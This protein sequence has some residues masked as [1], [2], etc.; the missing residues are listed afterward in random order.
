MAVTRAVAE[1]WF[2]KTGTPII[3]GYGLSETSP[4]LTCNRA[5]NTEFTG[6][7]GLPVPSTDIAIKDEAGNDLPLG[8]AGEICA[9][10]PQ[11][12]AGY[13]KRPQDTAAV[14]TKDGFFRTGDIGVMDDKG[15]VKIV[16]RKKDMILVS[17]FNVYPNE[18]EDVGREPSRCLGVRGR[19][20]I[21]RKHRR[22]GEAVRG[23]ER[24]RAHRGSAARFRQG[25]AHRL[26]AAEI[27]RIPRG[28]AED[29][30]S[31]RSSAARCATRPRAQRRR[32]ERG[33]LHLPLELQPCE[34]N[35]QRRGRSPRKDSIFPPR[36]GLPAAPARCILPSWP[37]TSAPARSPI[38]KGMPKPSGSAPATTTSATTSRRCCASSRAS[39]RSPFSISA[40]GRGAT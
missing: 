14:M 32:P 33:S 12:M 38:T 7:I 23:E 9:R 19:R 36:I 29:P 8:S 21:G 18:V 2:K 28:T 30:M 31:A 15:Q 34:S 6:T 10:G 20:R 17:G 22:G 39:C 40:A 27:H 11:V 13:W 25:E 26:Q 37:K 16:D 5:D 35:S 4:T 1:L 24:P 3:E